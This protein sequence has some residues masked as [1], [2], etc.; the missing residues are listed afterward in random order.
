MGDTMAW[1]GMA[2]GIGT[3][4]GCWGWIGGVGFIL[5]WVRMGWLD[6]WMHILGMHGSNKIELDL[7]R[8]S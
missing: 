1:C 6:M 4:E 2:G 8:P 5:P 3:W 7:G